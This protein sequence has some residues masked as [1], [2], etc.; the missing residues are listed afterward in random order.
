M[1]RIALAWFG[2]SLAF[3]SSAFAQ[4]GPPAA[5][6]DGAVRVFV[7]AGQSNAVGVDTLNELSTDQ[8]APQPNVLFYGPNER[9]NIW[10]PLTPSSI[11]PNLIDG[12]N[13]TGGSFGPEISTGKTISKALGG[14]LVAE[15]KFAVGGTA[16]FDRWN[17][18]S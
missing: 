14:A 18:A 1:N 16:L 7:F 4:G 13:R 10:G 15:V 17:P 11:S 9:G 3:A 12:I 5:T 6:P 2:L 8:L